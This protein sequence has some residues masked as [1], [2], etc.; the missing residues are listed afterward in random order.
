MKSHKP[1]NLF[2]GFF[3]SGRTP[4]Q[5]CAHDGRTQSVHPIERTARSE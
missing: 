5:A 4:L 3:V 2:A 1:V